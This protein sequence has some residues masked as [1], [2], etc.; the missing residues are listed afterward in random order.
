MS[1]LNL[2]KGRQTATL[3][4]RFHLQQLPGDLLQRLFVFLQ[5][6][7][8]TLV[9]LVDKVCRLL[10]HI[11]LCALRVFTDDTRLSR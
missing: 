2:L 5:H 9:A 11:G 7:K 1:R 6:G 10:I 8:S 4:Q 3:I